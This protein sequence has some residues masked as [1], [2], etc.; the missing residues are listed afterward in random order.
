MF[1]N[2]KE[3][4]DGNILTKVKSGISDVLSFVNKNKGI[5]N[6]VG[7][8][9]STF[10][11][12][13]GEVIKGATTLASNMD[14][15]HPIQGAINITKSM[16]KDF[17]NPIGGMVND[18]REAVDEITNYL[19]KS[20]VQ[21]ETLIQI[22]RGPSATTLEDDVYSSTKDKTNAFITN[23]RKKMKKEDYLI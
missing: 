20:P 7:N 5:I 6:T 21:Q 16:A 3:P 12:E 11:P 9:V 8:V 23:K 17:I 18:Y 10:A 14:I 19:G 2:G 1:S 15:E 4:K 13:V 22:P